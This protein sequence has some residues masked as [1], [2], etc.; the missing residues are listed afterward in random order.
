MFMTSRFFNIG[1][2]LILGATASAAWAAE[3]GAASLDTQSSSTAVTQ[4]SPVEPSAPADASDVSALAEQPGA[5]APAD[6]PGAPAAFV[7]KGS[8]D[9]GLSFES[10][11]A[12]YQNWNSQFVRGV[13][14]SSPSNTWNW[15]VVHAREF[16]KQGALFVGGNT[17]VINDDWYVSTFLN[18]SAGGFFLP[19]YRADATLHRKLLEPRNLVIGVG[20]STV[21]AKDVHRDNAVLLNAAYYFKFPLVLEGNVRLT[22]SNP[23]SV[24]TNYYTMAFTYGREKERYISLSYALGREG[25]QLVGDT[26]GGG[27]SAL[28]NFRSHTALLT[29]REWTGR[30]WGF[31]ARAGSYGNSY[32]RRAGGELSLFK[33]F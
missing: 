15:E 8:I 29:W 28:V 6:Q 24:R 30:D 3:P 9:V 10:L 25:Y 20:F 32:Y 19:R 21:K 18:T 2:S 11:T 33:D 7:P 1:A 14:A 16:G 13:Y 27:A 31:Q 23:G 4:A 17:H 22:N 12:G 5:P 26:A